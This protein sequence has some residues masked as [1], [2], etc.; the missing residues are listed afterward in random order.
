MKE[1][2]QPV[3]VRIGATQSNLKLADAASLF[4][5][6]APSLPEGSLLLGVN[7]ES[8]IEWYCAQLPPRTE[9]AQPATQASSGG[10]PDFNAETASR[11][12]LRGEIVKYTSFGGDGLRTASRL[13]EVF[14]RRFPGADTE[15][16]LKEAMQEGEE[17]REQL[18]HLENL[19]F[20]EAPDSPVV[21]ELCQALLHRWPLLRSK[22]HRK[23]DYAKKRE[24]RRFTHSNHRPA[25]AIRPG[26]DHRITAM[27]AV[28][29]YTILIDET[30]E[31]FETRDGNA[32]KFVAVVVPAGTQLAACDLHAADAPP[33]ETDEVMQRLLDSNAGVFGVRVS[34]LQAK[35]G[36]RWYDGILE[37]LH[38]ICRLIPL[39]GNDTPVLLK[40]V[41]EQRGSATSGQTWEE[42]AR[43]LSRYLHKL[44]PVRASRVELWIEVR[45][46][47]PWMAY[48]DVIAHAW[49]QKSQ[50]AALRL[51]A[52]ELVGPCLPTEE[53]ASVREAWDSA[54]AGRC[55]DEKHWNALLLHGD[56][57]DERSLAGRLL[58]LSGM[59]AAEDPALWDVY[60]ERLMRHLDS[61]G[62]NM[63]LVCAQSDWLE[64]WK[65]RNRTWSPKLSAL[66]QVAQLIRDNHLGLGDGRTDSEP[67]LQH[68][69]E[70]LKDEDPRFV[71]LVDLHRAVNCTNRYDF[72]GAS[73]VLESWTKEPLRVP[74]LQLWAR[75]QSSRG[76]HCAFRGDAAGALAHFNSALEAFLRLSDPATR[77]GESRQTS[78][79]KAIAMMDDPSFGDDDVR[80][81]VEQVLGPMTE[82]VQRLAPSSNPGDRYSLHL[83]LRWLAHRNPKESAAYVETQKL[84][85]TDTGHPWPLIECYRALLLEQAG[86]SKAAAFR[87]R[88]ACELAWADD[89]GPVV[90]LIGACVAALLERRQASI[91]G[92]LDAELSGIEWAIPNARAR[93]ESIRQWRKAPT[94]ELL[95][96]KDVLPFNFR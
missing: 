64:S 38:W 12:R 22:L 1:A 43:L 37:L 93:V 11:F 46:D 61:K 71:C 24:A 34:D 68:A 31:I 33:A 88:R 77:E 25:I 63:R 21:N 5:D 59:D 81:A 53:T 56:A 87:L 78:T 83:L 60:L 58:E 62:V 26:Q 48:A 19:L 67:A 41:V 85:R 45:S 40:V 39:D 29:E 82:A 14:R 4:P 27:P 90:R 13:A 95:L 20:R 79:Y 94:S 91:P 55:L 32:G 51:K 69:L 28:A 72:A 15:M 65:P 17:Q 75:I 2:P 8:Q 70:S 92:D 57:G 50:P 3:T 74:G 35:G 86:L 73:A 76:Q 10:M 49:A 84:W 6:A 23:L 18:E 66:W 44:D 52:S 96:L 89:Q 30:G 42:A 54:V 36:D 47:H 7:R 80:G 16:E 9:T